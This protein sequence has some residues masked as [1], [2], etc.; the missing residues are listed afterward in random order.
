MPTATPDIRDWAERAARLPQLALVAVYEPDGRPCTVAA[1]DPV[2][3][4]QLEPL[5]T[6]PHKPPRTARP[7]REW[8]RAGL[9][10]VVRAVANEPH[11]P[12]RTLLLVESASRRPGALLARLGV[13]LLPF[14]LLTGTSCWLAWRLY[15]ER[16]FAPLRELLE[17]A[18]AAHD[19]RLADPES[20]TAARLLSPVENLRLLV[21]ALPAQREREARYRA[22]QERRA[23]DERRQAARQLRAAFHM[24]ATDPLTGLNNRRALD[25]NLETLIGHCRTSGCNLSLVAIDVDHLKTLNDTLGHE[26]GDGLLRFVGELLRG[27]LREEDIPVR[28]GGDEFLLIL[29]ATDAAEATRI[30]VRVAALFAQRAGLLECRPQ[31]ALSWGVADHRTWPR[32]DAAELLRR[33]DAALYSAKRQPAP[34]ADLTEP[35][36]YSD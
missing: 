29:P 32:A 8:R 23:D 26:A 5:W 35:L 12:P 20:A 34:R 13:A 14:M 22:E 25:D 28:L 1:A 31:P 3:V 9:R 2:Q 24:A 27:T 36:P 30:A 17:I 16:Y 19:Q 11:L 15:A 21:E 10:Y 18:R 7:P 4:K 33:A 6:R